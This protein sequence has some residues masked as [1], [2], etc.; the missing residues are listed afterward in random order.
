MT[1]E[2]LRQKAYAER[3]RALADSYGGDLSRWP[4]ADSGAARQYAIRH[5][6]A[7]WLTLRGARQLDRI[8]A[9]SHGLAVSRQL[10]ERISQSAS[11]NPKHRPSGQWLHVAWLG[12]GLAAAC[13]AGVATGVTLT[14]QIVS[15]PHAQIGADPVEAAA[16][17]L[18]EPSEL[19]EA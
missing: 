9:T 7:A 19:G 13:A 11:E 18:R 4:D 3:F 12:A 2:K 14:S 15:A 1:R 6:F 8:L 17:A 5:P 16:A 10:F